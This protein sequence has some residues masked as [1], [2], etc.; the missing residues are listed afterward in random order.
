MHLNVKLPNL[1]QLS[2]LK[3]A[4]INWCSGNSFQTKLQYGD[5]VYQ[6]RLSRHMLY[7]GRLA[8]SLQFYATIPLYLEETTNGLIPER[9]VISHIHTKMLIR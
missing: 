9:I 2:A 1:K 8:V 6:A 4:Y 7:P 5:E 3:H